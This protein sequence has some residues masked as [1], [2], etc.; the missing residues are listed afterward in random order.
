M[1]AFTAAPDCAKIGARARRLRCPAKGIGLQ[2]VGPLPLGTQFPLCALALAWPSFTAGND[3]VRQYS[4]DA[5][6]AATFGW[7]VPTS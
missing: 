4:G 6:G 5:D 3:P 1:R 7:E 2:L